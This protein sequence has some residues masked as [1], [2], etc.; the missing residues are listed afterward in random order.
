MKPHPTVDNKMAQWVQA[1]PLIDVVD[2]LDGPIS[3]L[4]TVWLALRNPESNDTYGIRHCL[5]ILE[6]ATDRVE[7]LQKETNA[8][9]HEIVGK[10]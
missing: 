2:Q 6:N 9:V 7:K 1:E 3:M 4:R 5:E 10:I 8:K